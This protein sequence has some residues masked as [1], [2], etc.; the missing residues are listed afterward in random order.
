MLKWLKF[1]VSEDTFIWKDDKVFLLKFLESFKELSIHLYLKFG[2][3][4][5]FSFLSSVKLV[6]WFIRLIHAPVGL[7]KLPLGRDIAKLTVQNGTISE[8]QSIQYQNSF[9]DFRRF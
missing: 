8:V 9:L 3:I 6:S 2:N 1:L 4:I 5:S 7:F